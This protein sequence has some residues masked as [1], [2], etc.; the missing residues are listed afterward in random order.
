[1]GKGQ[2]GK[3][4]PRESIVHRILRQGEV[5]ASTNMAV[6]GAYMRRLPRY[7]TG[8]LEAG[9]S[10]IALRDT[11]SRAQV[12]SLTG[13]PEWRV[14]G[15]DVLQVADIEDF[16]RRVDTEVWVERTPTVRNAHHAT[17]YGFPDPT[18]DRAKA[19]DFAE[20]FLEAVKPTGP[21]YT[22]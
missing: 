22:S 12:C 2:S 11:P 18:E 15:I 10:V 7:G 8:V 6:P 16:G 19:E 17:V 1:V 9:L 4:L 14:I 13:I 5:D 3:R 20:A 21:R